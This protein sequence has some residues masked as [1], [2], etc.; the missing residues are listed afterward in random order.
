MVN[1]KLPPPIF[2]WKTAWETSWEPPRFTWESGKG[3]SVDKTS[4]RVEWPPTL[5]HLKI[6]WKRNK[7][8]EG[9]R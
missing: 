1:I 6:N 7:S 2:H 8:D 5:L 3:W 9:L 4:P